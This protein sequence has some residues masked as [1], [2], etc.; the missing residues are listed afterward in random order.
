MEF[1]RDFNQISK[2]NVLLAGGKAA[3]LGEMTR[4]GIPVPE[5]FVILAGT[6]EYFLSLN[7]L[8]NRIQDALNK[9]NIK[10]LKSVEKASEQ[11]KKMIIKSDFP[12][13]LAT[14][15]RC[16]FAE[17]DTR[18]VAVRSSATAE[19]SSTAAWAGQLETFLNTTKKTLLNNIKECWASLF[20]P[21]AIFYRF[22]N[23]LQAKKIAPSLSL[24]SLIPL[25]YENS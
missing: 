22:E 1:I 2:K 16:K 20:S 11:I 23:K 25:S 9:V 17:F 6:F 8:G 14:I 18:F 13:E 12:D 4:A 7:N 24:I 21:Q 19:D 10:K 3:S 15:I 5:G